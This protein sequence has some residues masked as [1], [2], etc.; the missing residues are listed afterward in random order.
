[1]SIT[2]SRSKRGLASSTSW[3]SLYGRTMCMGRQWKGTAVVGGAPMAREEAK[4]R[5]GWVVGR[6][7]GQDLRWPFHSSRGWESGSPGRVAS[8]GG[9][10]SML[11]SWLERGGNRA[12]HCWRMKRRQRARL[13][14]IGRK[15][16]T[17]R[18]RGDVNRRRG[19]TMEGT[20]RRWCQLGWRESY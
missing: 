16:D 1:M 7:S 19:D 20:E 9:V 10:D 17:V 18:W 3:V 11:W 5:Y 2:Y 8:N 6:S 4:W 15:C 12:K 13:G 14:F